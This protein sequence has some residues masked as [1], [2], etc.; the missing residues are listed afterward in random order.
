LRAGDELVSHDARLI[1]VTSVCSTEAVTTVY[2][3]RVADH[4]TYFVGGNEWGWDIWVH[5]ASYYNA[6][7][8][9][10]SPEQVADLRK[11]FNSSERTAFIKNWATNSKQAKRLL[12]PDELAFA[13]RKGILPDQLVVHHLVPLYRGGTNSF[14]NLRVMRQSFHHK[15]REELHNYPVNAHPY[16]LAGI[17][18]K[19]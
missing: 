12:D 7:L 15:L 8:R 5:N 10:N 3:L 4:H 13:A 6:S 1:K 14:D 18:G 19:E 2:N 11:A 17:G 16:K 9:I